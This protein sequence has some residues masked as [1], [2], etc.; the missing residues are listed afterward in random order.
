MNGTIERWPHDFGYDPI[1]F[2]LREK[3]YAE[4]P[5]QVIQSPVRAQPLAHFCHF[6]ERESG[7]NFKNLSTPVSY[8]SPTLRDTT[9]WT[10]SDWQALLGTIQTIRGWDICRLMMLDDREVERITGYCRKKLVPYFIKEEAYRTIP[11]NQTYEQYLETRS[12]SYNHNQR[13]CFR[14][15]EKSG[16]SITDQMTVEE[17]FSVYQARHEGRGDGADDYGV[18]PKFQAFLKELRS[19]YLELNR[20]IEIGVRDSE[21]R[22][23]AVAYGFRGE[24]GVFC[25][26]QTAHDPRYHSMRLGNLT[27]E[28]LIETALSRGSPYLTFSSDSPYLAN[29]TRSVYRFKRIDIHARNPKGLYLYARR[30]AARWKQLTKGILEKRRQRSV[31]TLPTK[32]GV[33]A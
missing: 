12:K 8:F 32:E 7:L 20:W 9:Y 18:D 5:V 1:F 30:M 22:L 33:T 15:L 11:G 21:G 27:L 24:N 14:L 10:P 16:F 23:A 13:R 29:F 2:S 6:A 31:Q 26:F 19:G 28:K 17:I 3:Y 4:G 25:I